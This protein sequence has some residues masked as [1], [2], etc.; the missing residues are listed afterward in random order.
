MKFAVCLPDGQS[1]ILV[2]MV[3][4]GQSLSLHNI[5]QIAQDFLE[6]CKKWVVSHYAE[7]SLCDPY[8]EVPTVID[9]LLDRLN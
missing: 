7:D 5:Y 6:E 4:D 3:I 8:L 1:D 2:V 9:V